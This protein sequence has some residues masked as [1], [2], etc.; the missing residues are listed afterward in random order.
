VRPRTV[1]GLIFVFTFAARLCHIRILWIEECYPAAGALQILHG[2]VPYRDFWFDKPP[3]SMGFY[4][5]WGAAA[6]WPLRLAGALF[7]TL[8]AWLVYRFAREKWSET[9]GL[10]A[11]SLIAFF[12]TFSIPSGAMALAP[13]LLMVAPHIAAVYLAWRGRPFWSGIC[14][15]IAMLIHTKAVY[16]VAV[17]L[18]WQSRAV[19]TL[20]A[21]FLIPNAVVFAWMGVTGALI[22][23]WQQVWQWGM[24]YARDTFFTSPVAE[25]LKRTLNWAGFHA[26]LILAGAWYWRRERDKDARL[27]AVWALISVAGIVAGWRFFPRYYF[28]LLPVFALV[29]ARGLTLLGRRRALAL[30]A[31]L[32]IPL[33]RF[34][35]RYVD[36]AGDLLSGQPHTWSDL[37]MYN[38]SIDAAETVL[39]L[40]T[41]S[42]TLLVWGYRP[43]IYTLTR[44]PAG[45]RFLD[46][47][48]LT[49]VIADRHLFDATPSTPDLARANRAALAQTR[50]DFIV[51][52]LGPYSP[53]LAID[54]FTD[55]ETWLTGYS[56]ISRT[57]SA[58][59]YRAIPEAT[60]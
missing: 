2:K 41:P 17:C 30:S 45:T 35:P 21:G 4:L 37:A 5:L 19:P 44:L 25:G 32:L 55:L 34:G 57:D 50:P 15:G 12:L 14:A 13:D 43:D 33:L 42:S 23:Y 3:L 20:A 58:I 38:G 24:I 39:D 46:S 53:A 52:G 16:V 18:L 8:A 1:F 26:V 10:I 40:A 9:E 29:A 59:V 60:R 54:N 48:P 6:G 22:P 31:L 11:A 27:F 36:L 49:G 28:Q 51:D 47:Q 7:V 56:E